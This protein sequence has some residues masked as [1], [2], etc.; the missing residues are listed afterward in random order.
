MRWRQVRESTFFSTLGKAN[1]NHLSFPSFLT[2]K[3]LIPSASICYFFSKESSY[4]FM[5][6]DLKWRKLKRQNFGSY[7][8]SEAVSQSRKNQQRAL[9][10]GLN[11]ICTFIHSP[12]PVVSRDFLCRNIYTR[13]Q[14][15]VEF[16]KIRDC[17][18]LFL[19][20]HCCTW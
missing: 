5:F 19:Y 8:F 10:H 9:N 15:T 14:L 1:S 16:I 4:C 13:Q 18:L 3:D 6:S 20:N 17:A 11:S 12:V 2:R 7:H